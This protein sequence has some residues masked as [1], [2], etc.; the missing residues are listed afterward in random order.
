[1]AFTSVA[2]AAGPFWAGRALGIQNTGQFLAAS[3]VGPTVGALITAVGYP[4]AFGIVALA[5]LISLGLVPKH[6]PV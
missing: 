1:L 3:A 2:E 5:P 6:D 4:I